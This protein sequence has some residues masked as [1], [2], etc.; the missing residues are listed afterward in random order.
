M[1]TSVSERAIFSFG[2]TQE[3]SD[4]YKKVILRI[5]PFIFI[6]YVLNYIDRVNVSFAKLQF[7]NDL[8]LTDASYGLGVGVFYIGYILFE[9]PSN[10]LLQKIGARKTITRIMCL[11]GM[12]SMSMALVSSPAQFY[13]ARILLGAA[14]AGFFP[15][16]ILYLTYWFPYRLRGRVMSFFVLAIAVSGIIGGPLSGS[17]LQHMT[18]LAGLKGWQWLFLIEGLLPVVMGIS[19]YFVLDDR[20]RDASWLTEAQKQILT[21]NL[22]S[23]GEAQG[24]SPLRAFLSTLRKPM[25]WVSTFGYFSITWAGMVLNFWAPTIIQRSGISNVLHVGLLS[26]VPYIVGACGMLLLCR[27]SDRLLE[28]RWHF[29]TA[30]FIASTAVLAIAVTASN[31]MVA[32]ACLALLAVGYL[33]ATAL[34]WTI[35]TRFLT[36]AES[37]GSIA[38]ISS[39]GQI[40]SLAAPTIFGFVTAKTGSLAAGSYLVAAVLAAGGLAVLTLKLPAATALLPRPPLYR[41][42]AAKRERWR[43][44]QNSASVHYISEDEFRKLDDQPAKPGIFFKQRHNVVGVFVKSDFVTIRRFFEIFLRS[45]RQIC[46]YHD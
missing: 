9:V 10:L 6:C 37:A 18:G 4:L 28:R 25:L 13:A 29:A 3:E 26:A 42:P 20:P 11:W 38:F 31:W 2:A 39:F 34:F 15:G 17:I 32:V 36:E 35:P 40:G 30:A 16:I 33:S 45:T 8:S 41:E 12:I 24:H 21:A 22:A 27:S 7:Q 44:D 23:T 5:I 46:G 19:A 43:P 14:E 1:Q